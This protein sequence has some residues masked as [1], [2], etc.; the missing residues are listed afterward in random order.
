MMRPLLLVTTVACALATAGGQSLDVEF[1]DGA[2]AVFR[3][4]S[5][6]LTATLTLT[7]RGKIDNL[8]MRYEPAR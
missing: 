3:N 6:G 1:P 5:N 7:V 4:E 8:G 2:M